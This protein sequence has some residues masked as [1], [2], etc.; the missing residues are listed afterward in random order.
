MVRFNFRDLIS[1]SDSVLYDSQEPII[2]SSSA[3]TIAKEARAAFSASQ[4]LP[5]SE[6]ILALDAIKAELE[7]KKD[8]ILAANQGDLK[9]KYQLLCMRLSTMLINILL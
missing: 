8:S 9:V 5:T 4:M 7:A 1:E 2:M 3:E 6:R